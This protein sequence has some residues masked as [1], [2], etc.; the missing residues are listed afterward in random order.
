MSAD[1]PIADADKKVQ[2]PSMNMRQALCALLISITAACVGADVDGM[3]QCTVAAIGKETGAASL[4]ASLDVPETFMMGAEIT[5]GGISVH[6]DGCDFPLNSF[7]SKETAEHII[8]NAPL[9]TLSHHEGFFR[10]VDTSLSIWK[11]SDGSGE[12]R[13]F[14]TGV[15]EMRPILKAR[16]RTH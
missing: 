3:E 6:H 15:H 8:Q 9:E 12:T 10:V 1:E 5:N 2:N 16:L 13:F 11:F 7:F 14:V 4:N